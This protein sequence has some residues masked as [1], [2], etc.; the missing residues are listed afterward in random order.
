MAH[1]HGGGW[2]GVTALVVTVAVVGSACAVESSTEIAGPD[3]EPPGVVVVEETVS[4]S[5]FGFG[6]QFEIAFDDDRSIVAASVSQDG[7]RSKVSFSPLF[8][9]DEGELPPLPL[10]V[11]AGERV[12]AYS[13]VFPRCAAEVGPLPR[14]ELTTRSA[15]GGADT[16]TFVMKD[17]AGWTTAVEAWCARGPRLGA[18]G[19][20]RWPD[21]SYEIVV[22]LRNPGPRALR[23]EADHG[24]AGGGT[25]QL[26]AF[27]VEARAKGE[28][29]IRGQAAPCEP[30]PSPAARVTL[31]IGG[32]PYTF[33]TEVC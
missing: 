6:P 7:R 22:Q 23:V 16:Q 11:P 10:S 26:D 31:D 9:P 25:W 13:E 1:G 30:G 28:L 18:Y 14:L 12:S 4:V 32:H 2:P 27:T 19:F 21:G 3:V 5:K 15:S 24:R 8:G 33:S 29:V 20:T 17:S